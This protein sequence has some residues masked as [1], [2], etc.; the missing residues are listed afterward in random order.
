MNWGSVL[1]K[2][3]DDLKPQSVAV[4]TLWPSEVMPV[5]PQ[6]DGVPVLGLSTV[7]NATIEF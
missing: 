3:P 2:S 5:P 4:S 7:L 1:W 6:F